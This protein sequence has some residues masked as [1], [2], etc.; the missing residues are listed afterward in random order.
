MAD[1][2]DSGKWGG[3]LQGRTMREAML[4]RYHFTRTDFRLIMLIGRMLLNNTLVNSQLSTRN[5]MFMFQHF[6]GQ[7]WIFNGR[8]IANA[9]PPLMN[10][11][12]HPFIQAVTSLHANSGFT[13]AQIR[14]G[15]YLVFGARAFNIFN[16]SL[17]MTEFVDR[18]HR[19]HAIANRQA[20]EMIA[21]FA[22]H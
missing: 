6:H 7:T 5:T 8:L 10:R 16:V 11:M 17:Y 12:G 18:H 13:F 2:G 15:R 14:P 9:G 22:R 20:T 21:G 1:V 19:Y 3:D 4:H